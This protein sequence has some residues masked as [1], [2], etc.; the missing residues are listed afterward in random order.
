[1]KLP[2]SS[3]VRAALDISAFLLFEF[4]TVDSSS[5]ES[6]PS[7]EAIFLYSYIKHAFRPS[8]F[9]YVSS[10][11]SNAYN[12]HDSLILYQTIHYSLLYHKI[13]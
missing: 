4:D 12:F 3:D 9:S 2:L 8:H 7:P 6:I 5:I 1:M 10:Y 11:T 13:R